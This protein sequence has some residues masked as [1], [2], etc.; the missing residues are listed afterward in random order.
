[1]TNLL[2]IEAIFEPVRP[3]RTLGITFHGLFIGR[4][5]QAGEHAA[6][7]HRADGLGRSFCE[8]CGLTQS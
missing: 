8:A 6:A 3:K 7:Q 4:L 2:A 5:G 1:M